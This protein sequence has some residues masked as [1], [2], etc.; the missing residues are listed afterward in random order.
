MDPL[1]T[2]N[3]N[4]F[5]RALI[6]ALPGLVFVLDPDRQ[7]V[8]WNDNFELVTGYNADEMRQISPLEL[9]PQEERAY[10][11]T[12]LAELFNEDNMS[13]EVT[14]ASKH[15]VNTPYLFSGRRAVFDGRVYGMGLGI[16]IS[17]RTRIAAELEVE[18]LM[19]RAMTEHSRDITSVIAADGTIAYTSAAVER[20]LG[21]KPDALIGKPLAS[22][23]HPSD[24][25]TAMPVIFDVL[26]GGIP[27][28]API[29]YRFQHKDGSYRLLS[30]TG[31]TVGS[32]GLVINSRDV[33]PLGEPGGLGAKQRQKP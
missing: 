27:R 23:I 31:G 7:F 14:L 22:Y 16:D 18:R 17:D 26:A 4:A 25:I 29:E 11:A 30:T 19:F 13:V 12:K 28:D 9:I 8:L 15:G 2:Q 20:I 6:N 33:T 5:L 3:D 10:G 21:Y 24:I 32:T 1:V